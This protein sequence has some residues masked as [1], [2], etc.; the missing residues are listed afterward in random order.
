[1]TYSSMV[2]QGIGGDFKN[3]QKALRAK[4]GR[5]LGRAIILEGPSIYKMN[6]NILIL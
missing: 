4:K 2:E 1:M 3:G 5:R 6:N